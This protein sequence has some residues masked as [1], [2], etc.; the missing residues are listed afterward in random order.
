M[1]SKIN[2]SLN[3][4][5]RK[6]YGLRSFAVSKGD[7]VKIKSGSRKGEGGKVIEIDHVS[8]RISVE[9]IT[10]A[11]ADGKQK[12]FYMDASNLMITRL[13]LSRQERL[14]RIRKIA[15]MK[16]ISIVEPTPEELAPPE[17]EKAEPVEAEQEGAED[18]GHAEAE[19]NE[20]V[21]EKAPADENDESPEDLDEEE[22]KDDQ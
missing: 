18:T 21:G 8:G 1:F 3:S 7:I 9:G 13:D 22:D 11:K 19:N 2:V 17:E 6:R 5:L 20:Q 15:E 14:T 16:K 12:E 4:E 10:I